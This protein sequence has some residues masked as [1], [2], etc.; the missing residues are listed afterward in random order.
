MLPCEDGADIYVS[1]FAYIVRPQS[2]YEFVLRLLIRTHSDFAAMES[3]HALRQ[4][5]FCFFQLL[6][7]CIKGSAGCRSPPLFWLAIKPKWRDL[8]EKDEFAGYVSFF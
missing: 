6:H 2:F 1:P 7:K 8:N 5:L 3:W 4:G